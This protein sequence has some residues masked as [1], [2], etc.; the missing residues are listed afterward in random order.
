MRESIKFDKKEQLEAKE[1]SIGQVTME[2]EEDHIGRQ[3]EG[4]TLVGGG[5]FIVK[6]R[7]SATEI[8]QQ[9]PNTINQFSSSN[10]FIVEPSEITFTGFSYPSPYVCYIFL[11]FTLEWE[12]MI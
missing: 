12:V 1:Q 4:T 5:K 8:I 11:F 9:M 10:K 7:L 3:V 6:T 2:S